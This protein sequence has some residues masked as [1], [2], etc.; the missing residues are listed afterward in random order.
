MGV[1][2]T[3]H[4]VCVCVC[5]AGLS[6]VQMMLVAK[7]FPVELLRCSGCWYFGGCWCDTAAE[8]VHDSTSFVGLVYMHATVKLKVCSVIAHIECA[9]MSASFTA[10]WDPYWYSGAHTPPRIRNQ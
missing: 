7:A 3:L 5:L 1:N 8:G 10:N 4:S 9:M 6:A 2:Q